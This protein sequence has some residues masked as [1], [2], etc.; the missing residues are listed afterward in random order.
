[1]R[2]AST[3]LGGEFSASSGVLAENSGHSVVINMKK[4][5][6]H[7]F[8]L[9]LR[10]SRI[11]SMDMKIFHSSGKK[12]M[13]S[14]TTINCTFGTYTELVNPNL[15]RKNHD[16]RQPLVTEVWFTELRKGAK[17]ILLDWQHSWRQSYFSE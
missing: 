8:R 12:M 10:K 2:S 3:P 16:K 1:M 9:H 15:Y 6:Q 13:A 5:E 17:Q 14:L 4:M 11:P 7:M